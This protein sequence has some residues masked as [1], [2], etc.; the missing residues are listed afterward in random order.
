MQLRAS[1]ISQTQ[2][3]EAIAWGRGMESKLHILSY[4]THGLGPWI[5]SWIGPWIG[6]WLGPWIRTVEPMWRQPC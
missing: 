4:L 6:P 3:R 2:L 5:G 1:L